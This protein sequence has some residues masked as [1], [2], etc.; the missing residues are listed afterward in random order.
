MK[1]TVQKQV[2][3]LIGLTFFLGGFATGL[4][5]LLVPHF[6]SIFSLDHARAGLVPTCF[7]AAYLFI[8]PL[9]GKFFRH[10]SMQAG[11]LLSLATMMV[12]ALLFAPAALLGSFPLFLV[13]LFVLASGGTLM[14]FFGNPYLTRLGTPAEASRRLTFMIAFTPLGTSLAGPLAGPWLFGGTVLQGQDLILPYALMAA[15]TLLLFILARLITWPEV[16]RVEAQTIPEQS[17]WKVAQFR[18]G[19]AAIFGYV[20]SEVAIGSFLVAAAGLA[21]YGG[22][23]ALVATKLVGLYWAGAMVGRFVGPLYMKRLGSTL[24]LSLHVAAAMAC[25]L[26]FMFGTGVPVLA[27]LVAVGYCNSI[28]YPTITALSL[29]DTGEMAPVGSSVLCTAVAGGALMPLLQGRLADAAGLEVSFVLPLL[30]YVVV[31][32]F[33]GFCR[34]SQT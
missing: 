16:A 14:Q 7:F 31:L 1:S 24:T 3:L 23:T 26:I 32:A 2:L 5:D 8:S 33:V 30:G 15:L 22:L 34:R 11:M 6:K 21:R 25:V 4:N 28:M 19:A 20:G 29:K 18:W 27:C 12:G 9:A 10:K 13:G 17:W